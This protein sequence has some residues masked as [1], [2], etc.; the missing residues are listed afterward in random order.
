MLWPDD[1]KLYMSA[2]EIH[3]MTEEYRLLVA[4]Y[5]AGPHRRRVERIDKAMILALRAHAGARRGSGVPYIMHPLAVA[6]IV[7]EELKLGST[8]ICAALL[9][10]VPEH[11]EQDTEA[12]RRI[13]DAKI[14]DIVEGI[15]RISGG[16]LTAASLAESEDFRLMLLSMSSDVRVIIVKMAE[17]LHNMRTLHWA[18]PQKQLPLA[19]ETLYV[20][21]PLAE[22]LGL[23]ALKRE[24]ENLAFK[25]LYPEENDMIERYLSC[26][27]SRRHQIIAEFIEPVKKCLDATGY[28]YRITSRLKTPCSIF[29][30]MRKKKIPIQEIFDIYAIRV[31]FESGPQDREREVCRNIRGIFEKL[32]PVHPDRVRD[33]VEIPKANG[34]R[35]LHL[36]CR[37]PHGQWIEVQIR[38]QAMDELAELGYAAHWKY[39]T[40]DPTVPQVESWIATIRNVLANPDSDGLDSLDSIRLGLGSQEI[41]VFSRHGEL[42][43]LPAGATVAD[44]AAVI[45]AGRKCIG[46]KINRTLVHTS[47]VLQ[48][49]DQVELLTVAPP[50][51]TT[52]HS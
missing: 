48:S 12:I 26:E 38:S 34:Y 8:S 49:G 51:K 31:I 30:K 44:M 25:F 2:D 4:A 40:Q 37:N 32:Y 23:Y 14:A 45:A 47:H 21:S 35:A 15:T 41:F 19:R 3:R 36:T 46:A 10:D 9:H 39:K 11:T 6:R 33:W 7:A 24:L 22:R 50:H 13:L 1:I 29:N 5:L 43:R 42:L 18:R 27:A 16:L 52:N 20:Y 28:R 17:R